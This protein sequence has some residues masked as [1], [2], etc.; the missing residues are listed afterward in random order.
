MT[1]RATYQQR[2]EELAAH[3]LEH[4][5]E[6][7]IEVFGVRTPCGTTACI[8]GTAALLA[9]KQGLCVVNW[10]PADEDDEDHEERMALSVTAGTERRDVDH[11]ARDYLG[12]ISSALFY[13]MSLWMPELAADA[14]LKAPYVVD[15]Q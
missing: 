1:D 11:W 9:Q 5:K 3:I 7:A 12:L 4:P 2:R 10:H 13:D 15:S 6:F 14:I 8:A